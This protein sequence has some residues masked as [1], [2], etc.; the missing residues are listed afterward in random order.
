MSR[1]AGR[2]LPSLRLVLTRVHV[3]V[4][5]F[6]VAVAGITV[7][8]TGIA[9]VVATSRNNLRLVAQSASYTVAPAVVFRDADAVREAIAPFASDGV[10]AIRVVTASGETLAEWHRPHAAGPSIAPAIAALFFA[11]P[12][13]APVRLGERVVGRILVSGDARDIAGYIGSGI[14]GA[15]ACLT[16]TAITTRLL[17]VRLQRVV[18]E[19]LSAI[20]ELAHSVRA[21]RAFE[22]RAPPSTIAEIDTLSSDFNALLA[23][24]DTWDRQWRSENARLSHSAAHDAL[25]G[26]SNRAHFEHELENAIAKARGTAR[27]FAILYLDGD[28]FKMVNDRH[29]HSAGDAVLVEVASRLRASLRGGDVAA[30]LGGDEFALLLAPPAGAQAVARVRRAVEAAM[31]PPVRLPSGVALPVGVSIGAA[32]YPRD[33]DDAAALIAAADADMYAEKHRRTMPSRTA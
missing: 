24:L 15:L 11:E 19:P 27:S 16:L 18:V 10:A 29:G 33:G 9:T 2:P 17:A 31:A 4:T 26:L 14:I 12:A 3:R 6:A 30:R 20:A 13:S 23:E 25:T 28:G 7:M 8:L 21:E 1:P 32:V 22:R 5:L